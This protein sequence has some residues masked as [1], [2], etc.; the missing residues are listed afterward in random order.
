M[1]CSALEPIVALYVEGDLPE[2]E[3]HRVEGHLQGCADC[4]SLAAELRECQAMVKSLRQGIVNT[5]ALSEVRA[6]VLTEVGDLEPAPAWALFMHQVVFAGLRRK[7]A[8]AGIVI[9]IV[10]SSFAWQSYRQKSVTPPAPLQVARIEP[11]VVSTVK[12]PSAGASRT[13]VPAR[14]SRRHES[15]SVARVAPVESSET[16]DVPVKETGQ[17][18]IKLLTD[19]PDITI[20]WL[21][22]EKPDD[23]G[24]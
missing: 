23:K 13:V 6:R 21:M 16:A 14:P 10:A 2:S 15:E 5:A 9:C 1:K 8:I 22:D 11:A 7:T 24:D 4:R 17:I 18:M 12:V 20:Y 3:R 19:N